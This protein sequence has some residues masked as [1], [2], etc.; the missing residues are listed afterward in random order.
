MFEGNEFIME[1][2]YPGTILQINSFMLEDFVHMPIRCFTDSKILILEKEY[3]N[4]ELMTTH[5]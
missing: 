3:F 1:K 5:T 4:D 2:L